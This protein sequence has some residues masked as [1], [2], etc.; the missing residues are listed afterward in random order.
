MIKATLG[1][2]VLAVIAVPCE[3]TGGEDAL[4]AVK[5]MVLKQADDWNA[6]DLDGF[7][8]GYWNSPELVFQSGGTRIRGFQAVRE[9]YV[10]LYQSEGRELGRLAFTDLELQELAA[11]H[12]SVIGAWQ[13]TRKDGGKSSGLFTLVVRKFPEGWRIVLDHTSGAN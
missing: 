8:R 13:V 11:D 6:A 7:L 3:A 1:L 5:A 2:V 10:K 9:R 4:A 12:V